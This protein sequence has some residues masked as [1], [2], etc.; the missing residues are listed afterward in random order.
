M[1]ALVV[2]AT[3][4]LGSAIARNLNSHAVESHGLARSVENKAALT[5]AGI[6]PVECD[7][8]DAKQHPA[9]AE[10]FEIVV[11]AAAMPFELDYQVVSGLVD[12]FRGS[13]RHL[14]YASGTGVLGIESKDGRW[15]ENT[16]AED[17]PFPFPALITRE[18]RLKT[19]G[20]VRA[21][22]N[23]GLHTTVIRPPLLFGR[24]GSSHVPMIFKSIRKTGCACYV[25]RG[26]NL[27]S[28]VHVEDAAEVFRLAIQKGTPG[29]LYHSVAGE[30][31]F[32]SIAEAAA[33]VAGC[34]TKSV[35]FDEACEIW[36]PA[37]VAAGLAVNSRSRCPRTRRELDWEPQHLD[38]I[39][40]IRHGSYR[41]AYLAT[42]R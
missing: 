32:R 21:A 18:L 6:M 41:D 36:H 4:Y 19:E 5:A 1:K 3:G 2:G 28:N 16:F 24:G 35:S 23:D 11:L 12:S 31:N 29:A 37:A 22:A 15:D 38:L 34:Q 8:A 13:G 7:L 40:D 26:L 42:T 39:D 33:E 10:Q 25:G 30:A 17:D 20:Y 27:Y 14:I 9:L